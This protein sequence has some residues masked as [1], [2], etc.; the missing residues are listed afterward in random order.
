M[1]NMEKAFR[2]HD[3]TLGLTQS[4]T[5]RS[6][7]RSGEGTPVDEVMRAINTV[8]MDLAAPV[9]EL[10]YSGHGSTLTGDWCFENRAGAITDHIT[11][12]DILNMWR[13][14]RSAHSN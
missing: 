13:R 1:G 9:V 11:F 10:Y 8:M 7:R 12:K 3:Q 6:F 5:S 14:A 2:A 4:S